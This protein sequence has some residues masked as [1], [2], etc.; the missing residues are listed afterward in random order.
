MNTLDFDTDLTRRIDQWHPESLIPGTYI[1]WNAKFFK[2][3]KGISW[4]VYEKVS[5][6]VSNMRKGEVDNGF[7]KNEP[8]RENK[9]KGQ[10]L[11]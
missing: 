11:T 10:F 5:F 7:R 8:N 6:N 1:I 2:I 4:E 3:P 9:A